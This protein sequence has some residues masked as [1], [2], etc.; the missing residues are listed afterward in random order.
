MKGID[1][2]PGAREK[3]EWDLG[4]LSECYY[5]PSSVLCGSHRST[6]P[7]MNSWRRICMRGTTG[8]RTEMMLFRWH[9]RDGTK[10]DCCVRMCVIAQTRGCV[11]EA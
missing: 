7:L 6:A 5:V 11:I 10:H 1:P 4:T 3:F 2:E 9:L 8:R